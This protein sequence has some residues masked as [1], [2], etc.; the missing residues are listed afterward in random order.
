MFHI[1]FLLR[2]RAQKH[3]ESIDFLNHYDTLKASNGHSP[4]L[5]E[6]V[7]KPEAGTCTVSAL[8]ASVASSC[9]SRITFNWCGETASEREGRELV[10]NKDSVS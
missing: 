9:L 10:V 7:R 3:S 5:K 6:W 4:T 2:E 8:N 1:E